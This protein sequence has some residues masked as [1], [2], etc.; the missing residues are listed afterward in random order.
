[1]LRYATVTP[2]RPPPLSIKL[3]F[4]W[5]R[6][7]VWFATALV[8]SVGTAIAAIGNPQL[9]GSVSLIAWSAATA[10]SLLTAAVL[11]KR[12]RERLGGG[13]DVALFARMGAIDALFLAGAWIDS[14]AVISPTIVAVVTV[15]AAI[16]ILWPRRR[17]LM[18]TEILP[19]I[20]TAVCLVGAA[21]AFA[22]NPAVVVALELLATSSW[23]LYQ[24]RL[25]WRVL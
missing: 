11:R 6:L 10:S 18:S 9:V 25:S 13:S 2:R 1:M 14:E 7:R 21:V 4:Q 16:G 17:R 8:V 20:V 15:A 23:L 3:R 22:I 5:H 12:R 19:L 24:V